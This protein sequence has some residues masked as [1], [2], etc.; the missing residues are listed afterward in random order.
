PPP[1]DPPDEPNALFCQITPVKA[2]APTSTTIAAVAPSERVA[3]RAGTR[4]CRSSHP[5][6]ITTIAP[7]TVASASAY[8]TGSLTCAYTPTGRP[9]VLDTTYVPTT[10]S[11]PSMPAASHQRGAL[12]SATA[13]Q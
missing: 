3:A 10:A 4:S 1:F 9:T 11:C 12:K 5:A 13:P 6:P 7:R 2:S 8:P